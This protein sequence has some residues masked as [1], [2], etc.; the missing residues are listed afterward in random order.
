MKIIVKD[1][2]SI[3]DIA[4]IA[5]QDAMR[6]FDLIA[7]NPQIE[8][9]NSNLTGM[10]LNYIESKITQKQIIKTL[11]VSQTPVIV[12]F[13]QSLFDLALQYD[14]KAENVYGLIIRNGLENI[15]VDPTG[16]ALNYTLNRTTVPIYYRNTGNTIATKPIKATGNLISNFILRQ[17]GSYLLRQDL[18]K[19]IRQTNA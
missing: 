10:T 8:N 7:A 12:N 3:F 14:G 17:D 5:Y 15:A 1:R 9:L 6:V 4:L 11:T 16:I 19:I 2:Q 13:N 18:G